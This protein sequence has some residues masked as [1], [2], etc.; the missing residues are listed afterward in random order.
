MII[1]S[2]IRCQRVCW[3]IAEFV[4]HSQC[5]NDA[6][7]SIRRDTKHCLDSSS[8]DTEPSSSVNDDQSFATFCR[9]QLKQTHYNVLRKS[10][11]DC[12]QARR[13]GNAERQ[14]AVRVWILTASGGVY[15][16]PLRPW[17]NIPRLAPSLPLPFPLLS[18]CPS[19]L[20]SLCT[21]VCLF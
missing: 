5:L 11:H 18:S 16:S 6:E 15:L 13:A 21:C 1:N 7:S 8:N 10:I 3:G 9:W 2:P 20:L 12:V 14:I 4:E 19:P 17:S